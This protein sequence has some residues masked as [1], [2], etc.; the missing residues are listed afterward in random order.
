MPNDT[1]IPLKPPPGA[2]R[3][4]TRYEAKGRWF[5]VNLVRW[6]NGRL[7]PIGGWQRFSSEPTAGA[8]RGGFAWRDNDQFRWLALGSA[9]KL[10]AHDGSAL[11]DISPVDLAPGRDNGLYGLGWG[12]GSFGLEAYGTERT[13]GGG[14]VLDAT[15]WSLD[16]FGELLLACSTADG[17]IVEWAPGGAS[18]AVPVTNAPT[19]NSAVFVTEE[20]HVVALG[21]NGNPRRV[22]WS[23]QENRNLWA[24]AA[25]NTAGGL[26]VVTPGKLLRGV[27]YRGESL[28]FTDTDL[29]LM[30]YVGPPFIYGIEK[31]GSANGLIGPNAVLSLGDRVVWMGEN[32]FWL[33]DGVVR[34]VPSEVAEYVFRD[35]NVLQGAK[36]AAGHNGEFGEVW[37]FYPSANSVENNRYVIWNYQENWW[38][39]GQMARTVWVD[40]DVWPYAVAA[41]PQ[42][43][44]YQH[45]QGW[46]D[47]GQT[48]VGQVYAESGALALG[49]G[50]RFMEVR[51]LIPDG[52]PNVPSCTQATFKLRR[53]PMDAVYR[54]AGPYTFGQTAGYTPA[55]FAGR[56]VEMRIEATQDAPFQFGEMR[57]DV[58]PGS[59]R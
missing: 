16:A 45:E 13:Q 23:S 35:I 29:H 22:S 49:N 1:L 27:R 32:S 33:Y 21:A 48:R 54:T 41:D 36:V 31:V 19:L 52:C 43:N 9:D 39:F 34:Q 7:R 12:T 47:S 5:D 4:G 55:R 42:G 11:N 53:T 24:A 17:R 59:G 37:W 30:R 18:P 25:T 56:Q 20:R 28:L 26:D 8:V 50:E 3:N 6:L 51:Q 58:V 38:S 10:Y 2:W 46:T 44:L 14:V 40:K 15:T 57:A